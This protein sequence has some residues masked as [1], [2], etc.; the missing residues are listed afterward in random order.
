MLK[1]YIGR[2]ENDTLDGRDYIDDPDFYFDTYM[3]KTCIET[4]FSKRLVS[5]TSN[6]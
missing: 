3:D 5:D 6:V 2:P 1:L 4:D